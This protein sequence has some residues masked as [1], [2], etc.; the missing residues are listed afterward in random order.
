MTDNPTDQF[1]SKLPVNET[2]INQLIAT[3][4]KF[5]DVPKDWSVVITDI[6]NSTQAIKEGRH[7]LVN[8][9]AT[10]S[11]IA[12]IN[13]ARK[14][15]LTI[16]FF[17]GGDG[18][19][20]LVP[21][22]LVKQLVL[23][24]EEHRENTLNNFKLDLRVGQLLV[25]SVYEQGQSLTIAKVKRSNQFFI[26]V[27][28]GNG[29]QYAEDLVK[30]TDDSDRKIEI[31]QASLDLTG[32]ECRWDQIEPPVNKFEV[33]SLLVLSQNTQEQSVVF[34]NVLDIIDQIY[35]VP[36]K[37]NPISQEKL[38]LTTSFNRIETETLTRLGKIVPGYLIANWLMTW[39]GKL[40][41]KFD[42]A[43]KYYLERLVELSDT[44]V[45]D[46]KINTVITGTS[47]QRKK[48]VA[49]LSDMEQTGKITF[50]WHASE[51]SVMSCYVRDR[52]DQHIHFVD[53]SDGGY[54]RA[55]SMVKSKI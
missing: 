17:F 54:T 44:L 22:S 35:G 1:Y 10:G 46:G 28:L 49:M 2:S 3:P 51:Q 39:F 7:Q 42:K 48:L 53:G 20:L 15:D 29:L 37:R 43:G 19:T 45:L 6:K 13:I 24:L 30:A 38:R 12:G 5:H 41:L 16:P 47:D 50:G 33:V 27:I 4:S 40:Y 32:M 8:L 52:R 9:I 55:A 11:I 21:P 34:K 14:F 36:N 18:A 25:S 31:Q 23:A 26:P